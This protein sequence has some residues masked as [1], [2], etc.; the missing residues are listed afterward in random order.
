MV[1]AMTSGLIAS[2]LSFVSPK[3]GITRFEKL[4]I[5]TS[6]L[7][8]SCSISSLPRSDVKSSVMSRLLQFE[9]FQRGAHSYQKSLPG[10]A[11]V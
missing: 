3:F 8:M 9:S 5:T 1:I 2:S 7:A 11:K 4:L 10:G 6:H